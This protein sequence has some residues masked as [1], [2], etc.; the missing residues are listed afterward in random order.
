MY[1]SDYG[2]ASSNCETKKLAGKSSE[3]LRACKDTNWLYKIKQEEW[4][5]PQNTSNGNRVFYIMNVGTISYAYTYSNSFAT[6]PV[7]YLNKNVKITGGDGTESSPY[8]FSL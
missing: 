2:Y 4:V 3:D 7:L 5:M 8:I 1:I 6:R